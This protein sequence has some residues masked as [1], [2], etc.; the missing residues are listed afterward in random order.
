MLVFN[1]TGPLQL[2]NES[3]QVGSYYGWAEET[4]AAPQVG[5]KT[6]DASNYYYYLWQFI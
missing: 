6:L 5:F 4:P 2:R 3:H 1:Q